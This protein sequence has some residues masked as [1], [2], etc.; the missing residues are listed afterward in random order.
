MLFSIA[1]APCER[2]AKRNYD[3]FDA[4][5]EHQGQGNHE[6][7]EPSSGRAAR[8]CGWRRLLGF[9]YHMAF[10]NQ[11]SDADQIFEFDGLKVAVTR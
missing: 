10:A 11:T 6:H 1:G 3:Q 8:C 5:C 4:R 2:R 9:Q 7:A